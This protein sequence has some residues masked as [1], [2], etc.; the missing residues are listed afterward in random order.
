MFRFYEIWI[1]CYLKMHRKLSTT[2]VIHGHCEGV[3]RWAGTPPEI[4]FRSPLKIMMPPLSLSTSTSV[5]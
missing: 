2:K 5:Q 3:R 1:P 4:Q